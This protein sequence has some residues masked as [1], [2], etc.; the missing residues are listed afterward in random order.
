MPDAAPR[1]TTRLQSTSSNNAPKNP[2]NKSTEGSQPSST[3]PAAFDFNSL[4]LKGL[5][6]AVVVLVVSVLATIET[7]FWAE[8]GWRWWTRDG[9]KAQHRQNEGTVEGV[10]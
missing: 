4:G 9:E 10:K 5:S 7:I 3:Q 2:S 6:K 8:V 1:T